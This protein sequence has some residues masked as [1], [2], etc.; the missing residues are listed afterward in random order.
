MDV[1]RY[2]VVQ[3]GGGIS[4]VADCQFLSALVAAC[5]ANPAGY[6]ELLAGVDRYDKRLRV[7]V[8]NSLAIFD[9]HNVAGHYEAIHHVLA[10]TRS[11][12]LPVFRIVDDSTRQASLQPARSGA[13]IFNLKDH[14]IVQL[15]NTYGD[16]SRAGKIRLHDG[17][18]WTRR[19]ERYELPTHWSIVP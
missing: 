14:R 10:E 13:I 1:M 9:E 18:A 3:E 19:V 4:F 16:V 15:Q 2:T 7:Y 17:K 8:L 11:A 12:N 5:A 6:Q